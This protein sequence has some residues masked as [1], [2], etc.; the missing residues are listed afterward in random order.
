MEDQKAKDRDEKRKAGIGNVF[1][2]WCPIGESKDL[3]IL[4]SEL[5]D[6]FAIHEHQYQGGDG[7]WN[8][9]EQCVQEMTNCP[10]CEKLGRGPSYV[11][12]LTALDLTGY[13]NKQTGEWVPQ[14][15]VLLPLKQAS[16]HRFKQLEAAAIAKGGSLRGMLLRMT[17][18]NK[19]Q[20]NIG[21]PGFLDNGDSFYCYTEQ[22]LEQEFG[23]EPILNR[24]RKVIKEA[25][26]D[27]HAFNYDLIFPMPDIEDMRRRW[28]SRTLYEQSQRELA[29]P[30]DHG[31][32]AGE[33]ENDQI[34]GLEKQ[35]PARSGP[36]SRRSAPPA[37]QE[38]APAPA[39]AGR[40]SGPPARSAPPQRPAPAARQAPPPAQ[41]PQGGSRPRSGGGGRNPFKRD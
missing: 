1:R 29:Q 25:N 11:L 19:E 2:F 13:A 38:Q 40:R 17:R 7:K 31:D 37:A 24:E 27:I 23:H 15:R 41:P 3:V 14:S 6:G 35:P 9:Y 30:D 22:E 36:P 21:E 12:Y 33:A 16:A 8:N 28:G 18:G 4:D 26:A 20:P 39:P 32:Q 5:R 34:P 10:A